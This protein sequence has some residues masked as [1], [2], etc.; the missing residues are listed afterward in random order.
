MWLNSIGPAAGSKKD[1]TARWTWSL[2]PAGAKL[3][4]GVRKV[5]NLEVWR[6]STPRIRRR[7]AAAEA[8]GA[9]IWIPFSNRP[10]V[11]T[12]IRL[13]E[14]NGLECTMWSICP[15]ADREQHHCLAT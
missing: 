9:E 15:C 8:A 14:I 13:S 6:R 1:K 7:P 10:H 5:R 2:D 11:T 12:E 4:G 3:P